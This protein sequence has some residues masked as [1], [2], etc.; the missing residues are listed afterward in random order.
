MLNRFLPETGATGIGISL[1]PDAVRMAESHRGRVVRSAAMP[2][3]PGMTV[4]ASTFPAFLRRCLSG[5]SSRFNRIPVWVVG[6][7]P[8]LQ[9]RYLVLPAVRGGSVSDMVYWTFR[10]DLPFDA[11]QT[12]FDYGTEHETA[13]DGVAR[14]HVTA[15]TALRSE[16]DALN[17]LF[18]A[19][20]VRL[21]GI[22]I[23]AFAMRNIMRVQAAGTDLASVCLFTG[24]DA[25][26]LI[27][28][29]NGHVQLTRVFKTG[30]NAILSV[31]Q[32][33][34]PECTL[35]DV[36]RRVQ[37]ALETTNET[38]KG[39]VDFIREV[40]QR[41]VQQ[42]ERTMTAYLNDHRGESFAGLHVMGA[43]AGLK[44]LVQ[45]MSERLGLAVL[46]LPAAY[47]RAD[48]GGDVDL[49]AQERMALAAGASLSQLEHTPNLLHNCT[50]R[51]KRA[52]R[53]WLSLL[54]SLLLGIAL[55]LLHLGRE[56]L[57]HGNGTLQRQLDDEQT[58]LGVDV[59]PVAKPELESMLSAVRGDSAV[60]K[61]MV[62]RWLP[63]S[64]LL[65]LGELTPAEV[66]L[67][68]IEAVFPA[69]A[70]PAGGRSGGESAN[71]LHLRGFVRGPVEGQRST[72]AA[73]AMR[74]EDAALF[75]RSSV[76]RAA[77]G[78]EGG[79][80]VLLFEL[81]LEVAMPPGHSAMPEE[82]TL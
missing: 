21:A 28:F 65:M 41:L 18:T 76:K 25:S 35:A 45:T 49:G 12:V 73:Y 43:M 54:V 46:A 23:P 50:Q 9:I 66:R 48:A 51:E 56:M 13:V 37:M 63:P 26:T 42:I 79:E 2:Y 70:T 32:K 19:A 80:A 53:A 29:K 38:E 34:L 3:P 69:V 44:P 62:R 67:T 20:G 11:A 61:Q 8:S 74:L 30:M 7:L 75:A 15:Y 33:Q 71:M 31:M 4:D 6:S 52:Q 39:A 59:T 10:K 55:A 36:Y 27:V 17:A 68:G 40:F 47:G 81:D 5:F 82:A 72:L 57:I 60:L 1:E 16:T 24:E 78:R 77:D 58:R 22:V 14:I 64:I